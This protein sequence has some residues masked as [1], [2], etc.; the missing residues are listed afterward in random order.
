[1]DEL[2]AIEKFLGDIN[3]VVSLTFCKEEEPE[4]DAIKFEEF[5]EEEV[6]EKEVKLDENGEPLVEE[7]APA[8]EGEVKKVKFNPKEWA[9]EGKPG[10][11]ISDKQSK[12]LMTLFA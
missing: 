8:E 11:T 7:E 10:W 3:S 5:E 1:M 6:V 12:N 2:F 9:G 4:A